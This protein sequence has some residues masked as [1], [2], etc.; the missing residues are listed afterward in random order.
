[1]SD[2]LVDFLRA[3]LAEDEAAAVIASGVLHPA[4]HWSLDEWTGR[5]EPHS[6]IAQ[7]TAAQPVLIGHFT[8]DPVPTAQAAHIVR[9]DP[10]RVLREIQAYRTTV[11]EYEIALWAQPDADQAAYW[12]ARRDALRETCLRIATVWADH[13]DHRSEWRP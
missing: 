10:A 6:L 11:D 4:A 3:R 1:M 13:P 8:A 9:H 7:G 12:Q 5:E 2:D